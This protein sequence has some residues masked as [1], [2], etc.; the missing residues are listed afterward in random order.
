MPLDNAPLNDGMTPEYIIQTMQACKGWEER[1]RQVVL[2]GKQLPALTAEQRAEGSLVKGCES[3]VW[4]LSEKQGECWF[5]NADS[6]SRIVRG[7]IAIVLAAFNGQTAETIRA[8]DTEDYFS[9]LN[10]LSH[11]S[12]SRGN[13]LR[14]IVN[15][16]QSVL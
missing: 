13:G 1:Y 14:D 16:I 15:S 5:F 6:D 9:Q 8:F 11:L 12:P 7:L 2:W 10:L 3:K 4:L